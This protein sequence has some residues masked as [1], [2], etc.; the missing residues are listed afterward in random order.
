MSNYSSIKFCVCIGSIDGN[1]RACLLLNCA[2]IISDVTQ[3]IVL[4]FVQN[5]QKTTFSVFLSFFLVKLSKILIFKVEYLENSLADF[6]DFG[7]ILQN[8]EGSFRWNQLVLVLLFSF[9]NIWKSTTTANFVVCLKFYASTASLIQRYVDRKIYG[10]RI[11]LCSN[12]IFTLSTFSYSGQ[13]YL[14]WVVMTFR[15]NTVLGRGQR[16]DRMVIKK[17]STIKF[18]L[19]YWLFLS[20]FSG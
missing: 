15:C 8:F 1:I 4:H 20:L 17:G 12:V 5:L 7:L 18:S 6:N 11:V 3:P 14:P 13:D 9:K 2:F 16:G 19:R 10:T